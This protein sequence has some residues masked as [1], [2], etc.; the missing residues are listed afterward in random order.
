VFEDLADASFDLI[1]AFTEDSYARA[2]QFA[3]TLAAEVE[4]WPVEDPSAGGE[5]RDMRLQAYRDVR[6]AIDSVITSR[7]KERSTPGA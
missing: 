5:T 4:L 1:V 7:L 2:V 6:D 3:R